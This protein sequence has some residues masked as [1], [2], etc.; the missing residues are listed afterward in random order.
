MNPVE[1]HFFR[2]K[3]PHQSIMLYIRS[4]VLKTFPEIEERY[5]YKIPFYYYN[6]KPMVYINILN[7]TNYVDVAFMDGN[8]LQ[9]KFPQLKDFNNR[10]RVRSIPVKTLEEFDEMEFVKILTEATILKSKKIK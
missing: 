6:K 9:E 1:Q 3:E 5:S 10:K 4:V 2:Q 8:Y 7:G